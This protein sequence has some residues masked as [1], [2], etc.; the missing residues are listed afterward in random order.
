MD[1][2][3]LIRG[4]AERLGFSLFG[5]T[6]AGPSRTWDKYARW[7]GAE[8]HGGM[9]YLERRADERRDIRNVWADARSVV[10][11]G[12]QYRV[13]VPRPTESEPNRG[14]VSSYAWDG[15]Y[16]EWCWTRLE[17]LGAELRSHLGQSVETRGYVD[18]G[19]L[20][21]RDVAEQAGV[22]WHGKNTMLIRP[23]VGSWF[24]LAELLIN[25]DLPPTDKNMPDRCGTCTRCLGACPTGAFVGPH[26][27]DARR[28]ISYLTIEHRGSIP[29]VLRSKI[30]AH[31]FGCDICQEVCP[32]NRKAARSGT[33]FSEIPE[34]APRDGLIALD[35]IPLL[36]LSKRQFEERF[37]GSPILRARR[38]GFLRNVC[39]AL[40]NVGTEDAIGPLEQALYDVSPLVREHAGWGLMRIAGQRAVDPLQEAVER[41]PEDSIRR[42][43]RLSFEEAAVSDRT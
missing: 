16:H 2:V 1:V 23:D 40:G 30:G 11:L 42:D 19:P 26:I 3:E 10:V 5:I 6:R 9:G 24:F 18:T 12:V 37:A 33:G 13:S 41:E 32:W 21:E 7:I 35:L 20:L 43:L 27:L 14:I 28:C 8:M 25:L 4:H 34:F 22:G 38:N 15:D 39:V 29:R 36:G 31:V 17:Q